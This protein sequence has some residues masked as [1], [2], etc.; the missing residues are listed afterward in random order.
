VYETLAGYIEFWY[1]YH[2]SARGIAKYYNAGQIADNDARFDALYGEERS[3]QPVD[4]IESPD[5]SS[6]MVVEMIA[7]SNM[8]EA[9]GKTVEAYHWRM[10]ADQLS[11]QIVDLF[12]FEEDAIFLDV[13]E[14][15]K[16]KFSGVITPNMFL[17]IWAGVPLPP[18]QLQRLMERHMLNPDAFFR[19]YPFPSLAAN[20]PQYDPNSYWRGRLW[21]HI[22][23]MMI[24]A[25]WRAGYHQEADGV[26]DRLLEMFSQSPWIHECYNSQT[27]A[28]FDEHTGMGSPDYNW[29]LATV[30]NLLLQTYKTSHSVI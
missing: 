9:L 17:P 6:F 4:R 3:N 1:T 14:G 16:Q 21:P 13:V 20:H 19:E 11:Q 26:A 25:L 5:L 23:Y 18:E 28:A 24:E 30:I 8:A 12:F 15:T 27:G 7:L 2:A 22:V 10:K 29:S